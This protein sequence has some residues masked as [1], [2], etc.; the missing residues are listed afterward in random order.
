[1]V[2]IRNICVGTGLSVVALLLNT[3]NLT[4]SL[5]L[6]LY[7]RHQEPKRSKQEALFVKRLHENQC[8]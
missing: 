1:M 6:V 5:S 4:H 3:T 2:W 7:Y 8:V